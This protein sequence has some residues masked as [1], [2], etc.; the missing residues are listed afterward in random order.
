MND[1][2]INNQVDISEYVIPTKLFTTSNTWGTNFKVYYLTDLHLEYHINQKANIDKQIKGIVSN[3]SEDKLYFYESIIYI[4]GDVA[5]SFLLAEKFYRQLRSFYPKIKIVA[6]L[7]NHEISE[8]ETLK[9]AI[10]K[11]SALF[12]E[13]NIIFLQNLGW[14]GMMYEQQKFICVGGIGFAP[15]NEMHNADNLVASKDIQFNRERERE[16]ST[17]FLSIYNK[18]V[19]IANEYSVPLLVFTHYPINDWLPNV[20]TDPHCFYF[21]G[22][23]HSNDYY[24][25]DDAVVISDN[26]IGLKAKNIRLKC[27]S[28]GTL[29]NP[30]YIFADGY[31]EITL[32][33]YFEF[34]RFNGQMLQGKGRLISN[35]IEKGNIFYMIK[36]NGFYMFVVVGS[37]DSWLCVGTTI[38]KIQ[39]VSHI[40]YFYN[41]FDT[42]VQRYIE[43]FA[44]TY[45]GLKSIADKLKKYGFS[46]RVHGFIIDIDY[47]NHLMV[48]PFDGKMTFYYSPI[49][50][51]VRE[52]PDI[53]SLLVSIKEDK[54]HRGLGTS[55]ESKQEIINLD[56][57]I[58][59]LNIG[60]KALIGDENH[61]AHKNTNNSIK[62]INVGRGSMYEYSRRM[63]QIQRLFD[64]NIL[65]EWDMSLIEDLYIEE[66][67]R[68]IKP[69]TTAYQSVKSDWRHYILIDAQKRTKNATMVCFPTF[70]ESI[71]NNRKR[72]WFPYNENGKIESTKAIKSFIK[73][74]PENII[75]DP[76]IIRELIQ[77]LSDDRFFQCFP[78]EFISTEVIDIFIHYSSSGRLY[79]FPVNKMTYDLWKYIYDTCGYSERKT[80]A[81]NFP[82]DVWDKIRTEQ[83]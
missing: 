31:H 33:E 81:K 21:N 41:A 60:N 3:L 20:K 43:L 14:N 6:V 64:C 7:G 29:T 8:F 79:D 42:I 54:L 73:A 26:Q 57:A 39:G 11:Y 76:D 51:H 23:N 83:S 75:N 63:L 68:P 59:E 17:K 78:K 24:F 9:D 1:L 49:F 22:H 74:I 50:G 71:S 58:V 18:A 36:K 25:L 44:T 37:K 30:F 28:V 15:F 45:N 35:Q 62:R 55:K 40:E 72:I 16:E 53:K 10:D 12:S 13:L 67:Y 48:N 38:R 61:Q 56:K 19:K 27:I 82:R 65:R 47:Y 70:R 52:Y 4:G 80:R 46:G 34:Y 77:N 32:K 69:V 5:D 66:E 2:V